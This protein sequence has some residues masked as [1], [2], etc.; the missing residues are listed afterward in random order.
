MNKHFLPE[1][2]FGIAVIKEAKHSTYSFEA[3]LKRFLNQ[4]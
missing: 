3:S 4:L 2:L 1:N